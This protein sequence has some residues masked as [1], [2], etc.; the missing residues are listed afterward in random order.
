MYQTLL[1]EIDIRWMMLIGLIINMFGAGMSIM[2]IQHIYLGM[3]PVVFL[4]LSSSI[5]DTLY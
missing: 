2:F 5:T 3:S 4:I 1:K